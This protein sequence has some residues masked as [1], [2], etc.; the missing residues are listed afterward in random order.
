ME[1]TGKGKTGG[2]SLLSTERTRT[3]VR[4]AITA[5]RSSNE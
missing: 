1:T 5:K 2:Y 3:R 4:L